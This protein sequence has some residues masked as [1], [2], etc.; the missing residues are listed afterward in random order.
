MKQV[1][2]L[3]T[4]SILVPL[5]FSI[6]DARPPRKLVWSDEF[7]YKGLPD[8]KKWAYDTGGAWLG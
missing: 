5:F 6:A 8:A 4:A 3:L 7:N 2:T 1:T